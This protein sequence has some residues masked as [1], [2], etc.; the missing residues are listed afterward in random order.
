MSFS[1]EQMQQRTKL[2]GRLTR[3]VRQAFQGGQSKNQ[4][5][6][7][8][9]E[10]QAA[11]IEILETPA[12]PVGRLLGWT[13]ILFA[14]SAL[15]WSFVGRIDVYATLQG[16]IIP[17]GNVKVVEPLITGKIKDIYV[18]DGETVSKGQPLAI[19]EPDAHRADRRRFEDEFLTLQLIIA[20][21]HMA[22]R[23][24]KKQDNRPLALSAAVGS[25]PSFVAQQQQILEQT[26]AAFE[27]KQRTTFTQINQLQAE[28]AQILKIILELEHVVNN[29]LQQMNIFK[30][31]VD[32][33][34]TTKIQFLDSQRLYF[35]ARIRIESEKYR[36]TEINTS[37][38]TLHMQRTEEREALKLNIMTELAETQQRMAVVEQE[39]NKARIAEQ[40]TQLTAPVSGTVQQLSIHTI[41][42]VV[43][44][45]EQLMIIVP[46]NA[47]LEIVAMLLNKDKGTVRK[48]QPARVKIEAFPF[49][50]YG[51]LEGEVLSISADAISQET[52]LLFPV[53]VSLPEIQITTNQQATPLTSGMAVTVEVKTGDRRVIEYLLSPLIQN[54]DEAMH[55][56]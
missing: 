39:L 32:K 7:I 55:E 38:E 9:R 35:D 50:S 46:K 29:S 56:R 17:T 33:E 3:V 19:I 40:Q 20:R 42:D 44:T 16:K 36:L 49:T 23:Y 11:A 51:V 37:I 27:S 54:I 6:P 34:R 28:R 21:L 24:A 5:G 2:Y 48:G 45:G 41:G 18:S 26:I 12:S 22:L 10:F 52:D 31:L 53:R 15:I 25:P 1:L 8:E 4:L 43:Q 14:V 47:V 13:I 30:V